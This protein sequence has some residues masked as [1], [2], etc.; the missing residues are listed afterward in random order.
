M[1][2]TQKKVRLFEIHAAITQVTLWGALCASFAHH[3]QLVLET[4]GFG[5]VPLGYLAGAAWLSCTVV[6]AA[7]GFL[8]KATEEV[9][10]ST[11]GRR[12]QEENRDDRDDVG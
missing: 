10:R 3:A 8:V 11:A 9:R 5:L 1:G 7:S 2:S 12:A 6:E 4:F